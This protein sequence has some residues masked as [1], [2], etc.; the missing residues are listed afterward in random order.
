MA[1]EER[2]GA[3]KKRY[4]KK[5]LKLKIPCRCQDMSRALLLACYL[6]LLLFS[7]P[8]QLHPR[9]S[10]PGMPTDVFLLR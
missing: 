8:F 5:K 10:R 3:E 4:E 9:D 6:S 1:D 7:D 2:V